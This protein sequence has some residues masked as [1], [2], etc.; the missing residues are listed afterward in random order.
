M[1]LMIFK[2]VR[3]FILWRSLP[4]PVIVDN[5]IA[6]EAHQPILQIALFRIVLLERTVN[7]NENF[8]GQVFGGIGPRGESVGEIVNAP[9]VGLDNL[10]PCRAITL[11]IF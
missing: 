9:A 10:F 8:L 1:V 4:L 6:R 2:I 7:P 3:R 5:Q 11:G